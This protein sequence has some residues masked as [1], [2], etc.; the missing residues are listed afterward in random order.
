[1]NDYVK[2]MRKLIG[3]ETLLTVGCGALIE[4]S[5]PTK[6]GWRGLGHPWRIDGDW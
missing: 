6:S 5:V 2:T 3:S 1:M 4:D